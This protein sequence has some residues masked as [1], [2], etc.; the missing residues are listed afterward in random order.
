MSQAAAGGLISRRILFSRISAEQYSASQP[1]VHSHSHPKTRRKKIGSISARCCVI[2]AAVT[3]K[4][5]QFHA[6]ARTCPCNQRD[7]TAESCSVFRL[8][9]M[10][11]DVVVRGC[12][13]AAT[14]GDVRSASA[15]YRRKPAVHT[16]TTQRDRLRYSTEKALLAV[17]MCD[18]I[19]GRI[20][21]SRTGSH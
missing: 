4:S 9:R 2:F 19:Q 17:C 11:M 18:K 21:L 5:A 12:A 16:R 15:A 10:S 3:R 7:Y 13:F 8:G 20:K 6:V 14:D 1:N